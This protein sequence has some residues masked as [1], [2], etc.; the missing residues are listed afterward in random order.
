MILKIKKKLHDIP[1]YSAICSNSHHAYYLFISEFI[2]SETSAQIE[3]VSCIM[4]NCASVWLAYILFY[5]LEDV[6]VVCM[7]MYVINFSLLV[8]SWMRFNE[9]A[10]V[11]KKAV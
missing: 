2:K 11:G 4:S 8:G 3:F 5:I 9:L 10:T 6:C 1:P 7:S